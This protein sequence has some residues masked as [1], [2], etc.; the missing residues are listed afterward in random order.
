MECQLSLKQN[1]MKV[2]KDISL[3]KYTTFRTG[4]KAQNFI[5]P[6]SMA[7]F[8]K[9][10]DKVSQ[11]GECLYILG[12]GSNVLI[13]DND[14]KGFVILTDRLK[15][16]KKS[17]Q[18]IIAETGVSISKLCY[19]FFLHGIEGLEFAYGLPGTI[20][21]AVFMNARCYGGEISDFIDHIQIREKG[22]TFILDKQNI[23][24][25]YKKSIFQNE[26]K[27]ILNIFF[28][29]GKANRFSILKK[30]LK[31]KNNRQKKGEYVFPSAGCIF[32]NDYS[33]GIPAGRII[34]ECGLKGLTVG[35]AKVYDKHANF[36]I[37][38]NQATSDDI[39]QLIR[40]IEEKVYE[41]KK[42]RL[43]REVRLLGE[44]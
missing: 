25:G 36:I 39:Y 34:E 40:I 22:K 11:S 13:S 32:K 15:K 4:G 3:A 1:N 41:Q 26:G 19:Y 18:F 10:I 6:N 14:L 5:R 28:K 35:G 8:E 7:E 38:H 23:G 17:G 20:G 29:T 27:Y 37:N 16:I 43:Q 9:A 31:N 21:G 2:L 42:I 12:G 33:I 44:F 24:F 30:M